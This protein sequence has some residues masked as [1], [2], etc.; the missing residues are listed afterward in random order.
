VRGEGSAAWR[1]GHGAGGEAELERAAGFLEDWDG[2]ES[3]QE[4]ASMRR[5]SR[6]DGSLKWGVENWEIGIDISTL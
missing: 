4:E 6:K 1:R 5:G 2:P 3:S